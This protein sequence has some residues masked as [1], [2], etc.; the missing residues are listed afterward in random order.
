MNLMSTVH[1]RAHLPEPGELSCVAVFVSPVELGKIYFE[2]LRKFR[3][4]IHSW[5]LLDLALVLVGLYCR[6]SSCIVVYEWGCVGSVAHGLLS[7][8]RCSI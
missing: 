2:A 7:S 3:G 1:E 5:H 4:H 6:M 8:V